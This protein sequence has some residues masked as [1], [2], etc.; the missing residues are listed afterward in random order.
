MQ[1]DG[2][3]KS[4]GDLVLFRKISFGVAEGQRIG[5]IAKNGTGK[6]TLLNIIAGKEGYDEGS[7]VFRRDLRVGYLEQDPHYPEDLTVLEACFY[8]GNSTV[9]LIK[10]YESCMET[11]GNPGLEELLA[12]MEHEK[13]WDY[14]RKAKQIL[15][16]LKIRD[17]SQQIKHLSGGQLKRVALANV[18]ITEPDFLIL[19]EPTAV[20]TPQETDEL[21]DILRTMVREKGMTVILITHKLYEVM[22][23]SHRVGVMR[24]GKL[25]GLAETRQMTERQLAAMMVGRE[26]V[27][28]PFPKE[29]KSGEPLVSVENLE[30]RDHRG[31]PAVRGVSF[32]VHAHEVLGIAAV[33]GNGQSELLEAITGMRPIAAGE[34][35]VQGRSVK[36]LTPGQI[37]RLGL[38]HVPEDRLATGVSSPADITENL[39]MGRHRSRALTR[40]GF[41]LGKKAAKDYAGR[42]FRQYDIR[43][44]SLDV[45]VGSLSGGNV[46][47]VVI[48]R[49]FSFDA[50]VLIISQPTR[51]VD[52][53]ATQ[54]IHRHIM[55]KREQGCAIL[56]CSADLDEVFRLS[57]RIITLYEGEITGQFRT[58][59]ISKEE[60]GYYMTGAR[61][62]E[63]KTHG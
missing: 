50:P 21:F 5:L 22:A 14:E 30:V 9:E 20:L 24:Q 60:L 39:I 51:G 36:G 35:Q 44:A 15:S 62:E 40:F 38:A 23:I 11:E 47:K 45:P 43:A 28:A 33:E 26:V 13:A 6:T 17:F 27:H 16:Q 10:E 32:Q 42:L 59:A 4:F 7:I 1:V 53:G 19:D 57:D 37:R 29:G 25:V 18:L 54:F 3:T 2:L 31:L 12:R 56:L 52:I 48:A 34:V 61:R 41:H 55:D 58:D 8:H 46:Q 63:E 49:E